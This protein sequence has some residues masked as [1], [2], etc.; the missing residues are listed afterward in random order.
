MGLFSNWH[1][2][3]FITRLIRPK[4]CAVKVGQ[5]IGLKTWQANS[6]N[7]E[8]LVKEITKYET[9]EKGVQSR[10]SESRANLMHLETKFFAYIL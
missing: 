9:A 8:K 3:D 10:G 2:E 7:Q 1:A 6:H 5:L 4:K